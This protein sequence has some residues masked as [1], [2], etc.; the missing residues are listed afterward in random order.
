MDGS[1]K[2][3]QIALLMAQLRASGQEAISVREPGGTPVSDQIRRLLL[4]PENAIVPTAELLLYS[5]ARAQLVAKSST[6]PCG[7]G[8]S[9]L[10]IGSAGPPWLIRVMAA[11]FGPRSIFGIIPHRLRIRLADPQLPP[12][13]P[14]R[15]NARAPGR[16]GRPADRMENENADFFERVRKGYLE[17]AAE[18]PDRFTVMDGTLPQEELHQAIL[19]K[20]SAFLSAQVSIEMDSHDLWMGFFKDSDG[21]C[22]PIGVKTKPE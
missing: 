21:S 6:R 19:A 3:T 4:A 20:V 7:P 8:K 10:P 9:S 22:W 11:D 2:T 1:G 5:A 12:G 13:Y 18:N 17:I 15:S 16:G 14:R